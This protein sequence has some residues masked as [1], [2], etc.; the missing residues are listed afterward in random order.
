MP[1]EFV[2]SY[3]YV[4][5]VSIFHDLTFNII[6]KYETIVSYRWHIMF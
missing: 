6:K 1:E 5:Y 2:L 4:V 3:V